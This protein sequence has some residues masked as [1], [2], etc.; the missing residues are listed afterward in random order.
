M[1]GHQTIKFT[2]I[3]CSNNPE[4]RSSLLLRGGRLKSRKISLMFSRRSTNE[5]QQ[6]NL[7]VVN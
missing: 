7:L 6:V 5:M 4:E 1:H 2:T 3:R